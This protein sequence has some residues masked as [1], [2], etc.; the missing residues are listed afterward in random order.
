ML[1]G[2]LLLASYLK[3][4]VHKELMTLAMEGRPVRCEQELDIVEHFSM[5]R[6]DEPIYL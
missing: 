5:A 3:R 6:N 4:D 2:P 1:G